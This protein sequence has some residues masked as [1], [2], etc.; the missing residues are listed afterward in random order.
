MHHIPFNR[1]R[2]LFA[3]NVLHK[4]S[5]YIKEMIVD[6]IARGI[7][8]NTYAPAKHRTLMRHIV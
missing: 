1:Y 4:L 6:D 3:C 2:S 7:I 5:Y 8:N